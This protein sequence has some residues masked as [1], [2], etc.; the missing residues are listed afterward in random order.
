MLLLRQ[1]ANYTSRNLSIK[2]HVHSLPRTQLL[3]NLLD[4]L[5]PQ[6]SRLPLVLCKKYREILL[7]VARPGLFPDLEGTHV[8]FPSKRTDE[9]LLVHGKNRYSQ[10]NRDIIALLRCV[11]NIFMG[12]YGAH[13][14]LFRDRLI[15]IYLVA[16]PE[17]KNT[18]DEGV[19]ERD[20][21][22]HD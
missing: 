6:L 14:I 7:L 21:S 4:R 9:S 1:A 8:G 3:H 16:V 17:Y 11:E 22:V 20:V 19:F 12:A 18:G 2:R 10:D 15:L 13:C 5:I